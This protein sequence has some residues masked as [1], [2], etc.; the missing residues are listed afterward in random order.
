M[1]T[2]AVLT[3]PPSTRASA[4]RRCERRGAGYLEARALVDSTGATAKA[5]GAS[6]SFA[7]KRSSETLKK[8]IEE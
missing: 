3:Q 7:A 2:P 6:L 4:R 5:R 1:V 8:E